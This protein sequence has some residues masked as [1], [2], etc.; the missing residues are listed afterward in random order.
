M[1]INVNDNNKT[2]E[3]WLTNQEKRDAAMREQLR[4]L[5]QAYAEKKYLVA[6]FQSGER[7][8]RQSTSDLLCYNRKRLAQIEVEREKGVTARRLHPHKAL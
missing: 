5:Y 8:L 2:V 1:E 6:V 4:P 7:D 3:I